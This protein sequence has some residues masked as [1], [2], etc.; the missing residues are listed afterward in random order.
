MAAKYF[1]D[2][3]VGD[4]N[5]NEELNEKYGQGWEVGGE[6]RLVDFKKQYRLAVPIRISLEAWKALEEQKS[7]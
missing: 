5:L 4:T 2:I 3:I 1:Y 7:E 6:A